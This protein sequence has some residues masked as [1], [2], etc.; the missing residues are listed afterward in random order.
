MKRAYEQG[1]T[2]IELILVIGILTISVGVSSDIVLTLIKSY[3]KSQINNEVEQNADFVMS[4]IQRDLFANASSIV[5]VS[6]SNITF[7][8]KNGDIYSYKVSSNG[9]SFQVY[10][11]VGGQDYLL[12]N[13]DPINGIKLVDCAVSSCFTK[14][15]ASG[16]SPYVIKLK[17]EF[18]PANIT[19]P[20][21]GASVNTIVETTQ[22]VRSTY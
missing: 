1:F 22:V 18:V 6:S 10:Y 2:L 11:T 7:T 12:T 19:S 13:D 4:K 8:N 5:S 21:P 16:T 9:T 15:N 20:T 14:L 3:G 17:F